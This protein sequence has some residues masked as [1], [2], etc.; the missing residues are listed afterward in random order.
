MLDFFKTASGGINLGLLAVILGWVVT[1]FGM[2]AHI[3]KHRS[4]LVAARDAAYKSRQQTEV[5]E[6]LRKDAE[7]RFEAAES[8]IE[9]LKPKPFGVRAKDYL[10]SLNPK[11]LE[12]IAQGETAIPLR[13]SGRQFA[14][15]QEIIEDPEATKRIWIAEIR[16]GEMGGVEFPDGIAYNLTIGVD[17][18][19]FESQ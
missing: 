5:E 10:N 6:K 4:E 13:I 11:I 17:P 14:A 3:H 12:A 8:E 15:L 18:A 1:T 7:A 19:Y 9:R 2:I 16:D